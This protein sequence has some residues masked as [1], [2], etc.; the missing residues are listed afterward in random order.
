VANPTALSTI[1]RKLSSL[2]GCGK[3][4]ECR[5][6]WEAESTVVI[7]TYWEWVN[8]AEETLRIASDGQQSSF[9]VFCTYHVC[10][11]HK[12]WLW[13]YIMCR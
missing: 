6:I 8:R 3:S 5:H 12:Y 7:W 10:D 2:V 9:H 11:F 13:K 1:L 4:F